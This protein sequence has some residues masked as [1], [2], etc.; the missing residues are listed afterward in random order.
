MHYVYVLKSLRLKDK[1]YIGYTS[2]LK[3]RL[4]E[5]MMGK[6]YTTAR[7][8]PVELVYCEAYKSKM[9]AQNREQQLKQY[10]NALD[11]LKKRIR[12]CL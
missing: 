9:D 7:I 11:H 12:N 8:L 3:K 6:N 10:G 5:H 4:A 1:I 2:D